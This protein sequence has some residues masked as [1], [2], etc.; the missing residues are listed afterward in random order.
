MTDTLNITP[1][2]DTAELI[3]PI[4][5]AFGA[6]TLKLQ[7]FP[8]AITAEARHTDLITDTLT[9]LC[10]I[11]SIIF[12]KKLVNVIPSLLGC[13]ARWKEALNL[14]YSMKLSRDR[15]IVFM[16][17][18]LPFCLLVN[19]YGIYSPDFIRDLSP[20]ASLLV[21]AGVFIA[22]II[23]REGAQFFFGSKKISKETSNASHMAFYT[24]FCTATL[25][26][27][28]TSGILH[29]TNLSDTTT[30]NIITYELAAFYIILTVRRYQIFSNSCSLFSTLLY[31]CTLEILP[32]GILIMSA[33][34]F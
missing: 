15:N 7:R 30:G 1:A 10:V 3:Q 9:T 13:T 33:L 6:G 32:T 26:T 34:F 8:S 23:I 28:A 19:R 31:L 22:Y 4:D 24:F 2:A 29:F 14:E 18:V 27:L 20:S 11:V 21:T 5:S 16:T 25:V 12:L 17:L